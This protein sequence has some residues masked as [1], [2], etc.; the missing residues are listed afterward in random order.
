MEGILKIPYF[1]A[2]AGFTIGT[3]FAFIQFAIDFVQR[4]LKRNIQTG[5]Q[6]NEP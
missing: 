6:N 3:F 4:I 2:K 5:G 1:P